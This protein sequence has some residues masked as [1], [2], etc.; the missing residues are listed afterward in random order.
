MNSKLIPFLGEVVGR[1]IPFGSLITF[2]H[3]KQVDGRIKAM[4]S[5]NDGSIH[6]AMEST[7]DIDFNGGI[8]CLSNL[9]YLNQT[10]NAPFMVDGATV[11]L[12]ILERG[13]KS[14]ITQMSFRPNDR[15]EINYVTTDP[16]RASVLKP[17]SVSI[18]EWPVAFEL[19]KSMLDEISAFNKI[20]ASA[21]TSGVDP[22]VT[23]AHMDGS[24]IIEFGDGNSHT[25]VLAV[26][27]EAEST[28]RKTTSVRLLPDHLMRVLRQTVTKDIPARIK[29]HDKAMMIADDTDLVSSTTTLI[30]RK[31]REGVS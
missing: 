19:N 15:M 8:A 26:D 16:F 31:N 14:L 9:A 3:M 25:A 23:V 20:N 7:S 27:T 10:V 11:E 13:E 12:S 28:S 29:L 21:P 22:V 4:A 2:I 17:R 1:V 18:S 5:A 30:G 24:V 6:I